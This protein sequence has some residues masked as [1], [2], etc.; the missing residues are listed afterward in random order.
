MYRHTIEEHHLLVVPFAPNMTLFSA[1]AR[2]KELMWKWKGRSITLQMKEEMFQQIIDIMINQ[3]QAQ[4]L[5]DP[6]P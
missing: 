4:G 2:I 5:P 3:A 6:N 1:A